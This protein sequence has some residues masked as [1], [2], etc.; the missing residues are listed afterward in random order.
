MRNNK[1]EQFKNNLEGQGFSTEFI[2]R[3]IE[4]FTELEE[5][6]EVQEMSNIEEAIQYYDSVGSY[7]CNT[8]QS[9]NNLK[10]VR[11]DIAWLKDNY[12]DLDLDLYFQNIEHF[13]IQILFILFNEF[14]PQ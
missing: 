13:E 9:E 14:Y 4:Y 7:T 2:Q 12:P 11:E 6:M 5:E 3:A 1:M 8:L 10:E